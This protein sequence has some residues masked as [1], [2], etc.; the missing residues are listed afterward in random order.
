MK[1]FKDTV[2]LLIFTLDIATQNYPIITLVEGLPH[3]SISLLACSTHLG[4]VVI[5]SSNALIYV[6]QS[7]RRVALPLNGWT[8]RISD[9]PLLPLTPAEQ[10]R[11]LFLE[12]SRAVFVDDRTFFLV[13]K[14]GTVHPVEIVV[15]GKTVSKMMISPPLAQTA[16]PSVLCN[17]GDDHLFVGSTVGP[18]VLLKAAHIE[19]EIKSDDVEMAPAAIVQDDDF[20]DDDDDGMSFLCSHCHFPNHLKFL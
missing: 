18:S 16:I 15:D 13:L 1:E 9:I 17:L 19:E 2:K 10:E 4:G 8:P 3:D 5:T 12:G 20:M 6:D 11:M 7:G 14:D